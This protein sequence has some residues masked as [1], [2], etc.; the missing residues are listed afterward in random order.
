MDSDLIIFI[1]LILI[2]FFSGIEIAFI[3]ANKLR[4]ELKSKKGHLSAR[5]LSQ[6]VKNP[7]RF[8]STCLIGIHIAM[9]VY[10]ISMEGIMDPYLTGIHSEFLRVLLKILIASVLVLLG[11]E[12]LPR[13]LFRSNADVLLRVM[14]FPFQFFYYLLWPVKLFITLLSRAILI[15]FTR[16]R[17]KELP[18]I[19]TREDREDLDQYIMENNQVKLEEEADVDHEIF[20]NAMDFGSVRV[21]DCMVHRTGIVAIDV[22]EPIEELYKL[23]LESGH[24]KILVYENT[25]DQV[26]GYVHQVE[27]FKK[28]KSIRSI[29]MPIIIANESM[30]ASDLLKKLSSNHR[31]IA[32]IV[33]EFGGT[34]GIVTVEDIM[35]MVFGNIEDEHDVEELQ[36]EQLDESV[37]RFSAQLEIEYLNEHYELDIPEGEYE[38]LGGYIIECNGGIPAEGERIK[39]GNLEF[40]ILKTENARIDEVEMRILPGKES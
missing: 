38:T 25:V 29:L 7:S 21:R 27:L 11:A 30:A 8:I 15:P 39:A 14:V 33:D 31:S 16:N 3:S 32:L 36:E 20:R 28:P 5:I 26:I 13:V 9:V 35:E 34:A 4:I 6:Y 2:A 37:F 18:S 12:L 1:T 10:A 22:E 24:S 19:F 23:F 17:L 40:T